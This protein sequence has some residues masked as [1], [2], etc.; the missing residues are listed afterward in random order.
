MP[1]IVACRGRGGCA[2]LSEHLHRKMRKR[3][4]GANMR[5]DLTWMIFLSSAIVLMACYT[6]SAWATP[7]VGY[8]STTMA[9]SPFSGIDVFNHM[10]PHDGTND[11][12]LSWQKTIGNSD[13]YVQSNVW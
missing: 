4:K 9:M 8:V 2:I 3:E 10:N 1:C 11:F 13:I 5:R 12:W 7:A 6:G